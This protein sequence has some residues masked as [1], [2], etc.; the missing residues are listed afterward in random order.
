MKKPE[1][2]EI[3]QNF[4]RLPDHAEVRTAV[5]RMLEDIAPATFWRRVKSGALPAVVNGRINVGAY[6]RMRASRDA[7]RN[8]AA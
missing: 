7:S 4:D 2:F 6:R 1:L 8:Q 3:V 5:I